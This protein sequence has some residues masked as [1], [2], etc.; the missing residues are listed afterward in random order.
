MRPLVKL[1]I[2]LAVKIA[3]IALI[4]AI[5]MGLTGCRGCSNPDALSYSSANTEETVFTSDSSSEVFMS[6]SSE[7]AMPTSSFSQI[8]S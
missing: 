5:V 3:F 8:H 6:E 1:I 4:Y 7:E 2:S